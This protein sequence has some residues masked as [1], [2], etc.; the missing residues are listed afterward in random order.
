MKGD[1]YAGQLERQLIL[2]RIISDIARRFVHMENVE[3]SINYALKVIGEFSLA[4]RA[5]IFE[6]QEEGVWMDN[7]YEWCA[8]GVSP[9]IEVLKNQEIQMFKWWMTQI[10]DGKI[11]D[12]NDVDALGPEAQNEKEILSMQGIKSVLVLDRKSVV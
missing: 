1:H 4:S 12:I 6:F 2:E 10:S 9:E 8:Q 11:L 3:T 5:Y 7:T